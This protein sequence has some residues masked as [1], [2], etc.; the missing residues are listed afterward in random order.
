M[1]PRAG[2]DEDLGVGIPPG[3]AYLRWTADDTTAGCATLRLTSHGALGTVWVIRVQELSEKTARNVATT[4]ARSDPGGPSMKRGR[5][6]VRRRLGACDLV[7]DQR[8]SDRHAA[9]IRPV[10]CGQGL[11]CNSD[12]RLYGLAP[13]HEALSLI[14]LPGS[15]IVD[16]GVARDHECREGEACYPLAFVATDDSVCVSLPWDAPPAAVGR[17]LPG[18]TLTW[19]AAWVARPTTISFCS[20]QGTQRSPY[21]RPETS[22]VR[23]FPITVDSALTVQWM[24]DG[25]VTLDRRAGEAAAVSILSRVTGKVEW[26]IPYYDSWSYRPNGMYLA[27]GRVRSRFLSKTVDLGLFDIS[28]GP[29]SIMSRATATTGAATRIK[30][31]RFWRCRWGRPAFSRPGSRRVGSTRPGPASC[32]KKRPRACTGRLGQGSSRRGWAGWRDA[33]EQPLLSLHNPLRA[34]AH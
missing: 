1:A 17:R 25:F 11:D 8:S 6:E 7:L 33:A 27:F 19:R 28:D 26:E 22:E 12:L 21:T 4:E 2:V 32:R 10:P 20:P 3:V 29:M 16:V 15:E 24:P 9:E 30:R 31:A 14:E 18:S 13:P 5:Q 23:T 34:T